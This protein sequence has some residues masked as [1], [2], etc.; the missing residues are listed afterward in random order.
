MMS[1][2]MYAQVIDFIANNTSQFL[3]YITSQF[4]NQQ[5]TCHD[6]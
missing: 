1:Q 4:S 6:N 2:N 3:T 5:Q